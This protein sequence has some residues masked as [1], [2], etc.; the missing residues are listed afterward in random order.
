MEIIPMEKNKKTFKKWFPLAILSIVVFGSL[1]VVVQQIYR[2]SANDPQIQMAWSASAML[3]EG[4]PGNP[5]SR[6]P[7]SIFNRI[8]RHS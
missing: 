4:V 1:Y 8:R 6:L 2:H 5:S 3:A 7:P